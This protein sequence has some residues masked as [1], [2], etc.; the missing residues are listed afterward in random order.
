MGGVIA[1][2]LGGAF[3]ILSIFLIAISKFETWESII[4]EI[5]AILPF[6]VYSQKTSNRS[7]ILVCSSFEGATKEALITSSLASSISTL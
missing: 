3:T 6:S 5:E 4:F 1:V 7:K 2:D